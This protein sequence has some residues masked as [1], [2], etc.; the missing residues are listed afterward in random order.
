[1]P[2]TR[3]FFYEEAP[4]DVPVLDWLSN[5]RNTDTAAYAKCVARIQRL[6]AL[7]H[8]LRR[9]EADFLRSGI[10]ELRARRGRVHL[11]ILYFYH[12]KD[13]AFLAHALTKTAEVR[14]ADIERAVRRREKLKADPDAH[15]YYEHEE[16]LVDDKGT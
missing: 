13:V 1:L 15:T 7:G 16:D 10:Y 9:P 5:L 8:E 4:G 14:N 2:K 3:I 6:A 12:G 11:R